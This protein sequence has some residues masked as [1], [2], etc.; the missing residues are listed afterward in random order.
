MKAKHAR[1]CL[2]LADLSH[3]FLTLSPPTHTSK[4]SKQQALALT[5]RSPFHH[6]TPTHTPPPPTHPHP[7]PVHPPHHADSGMS[8]KVTKQQALALTEKLKALSRS[9][10]VGGLQPYRSTPATAAA[11][12][13]GRQGRRSPGG[14]ASMTQEQLAEQRQ[15][16][17]EMEQV[18]WARRIM[19]R[20]PCL[21][22]KS[23]A[24]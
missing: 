22:H 12:A 5:E 8:G 24:T 7:T 14:E 21:H 9:T 4:V 16:D 19:W 3:H 6:P 1:I 10:A 15:M 11:A 17:R 23:I 18:G 2:R 13:G 20:Y